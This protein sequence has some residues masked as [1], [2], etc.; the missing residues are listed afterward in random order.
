MLP[1]FSM[2]TKLVAAVARRINLIKLWQI[3]TFRPE[4]L[5]E[6]D[7][8]FGRILGIAIVAIISVA[9]AR[10][11][12]LTYKHNL[13]SAFFYQTSFG[14]AVNFACNGEYNEIKP[15]QEVQRFLER[16]SNSLNSCSGVEGLSVRTIS[17]LESSMVYL[18]LVSAAAWKVLGFN[19]ESLF[20]VAAALS[21][22]FALASYS[23]LRVFFVSRLTSA[24][25]TS[26]VMSSA[27]VVAQIPQLRDFSKAPFLIGALA[28][29]G[30]AVL[31][32]HRLL[33]ILLLATGAGAL[34]SI[35]LGFRPDLKVVLPIA[36]LAPLLFIGDDAL[37]PTAVRM[38]L[39]WVGF[40]A[41]YVCLQLPLNLVGEA[42]G[43]G[44]AT[45]IPHVLI[46]GFAEHFLRA[47]LGMSDSSYSALRPYLDE[48]VYA[49]VNLF[50]GTPNAS[51][52][53]LWGSAQYDQVSTDLLRSILLLVPYDTFFRGLYSANAIGHL[54]INA[55]VW[56]VPLL[57]VTP[58]LLVVRLR[59]FL[60]VMLVFG[61]LIAVLSLQYDSRHAFYML[62]LGAV[63][64]VLS[65]SV[66][67]E[68]ARHVRSFGF[69]LPR[70]TAL[71]I[72]S[73]LLSVVLLA[74]SLT[75]LSQFLANSQRKALQN[76]VGTYAGLEWD[77]IKFRATQGEIEPEPIG[78]ADG[79]R[80]FTFVLKQPTGREPGIRSGTQTFSRLTFKLQPTDPRMECFPAAARVSANYKY[81]GE[82]INLGGFSLPPRAGTVTYYFPQA[83]AGAL[84]FT[85][86]ELDG[87]S[88]DCIVD[89]SVAKDFPAGTV[90]A[91]LLL[92]DGQLNDFQ[93]GD[94]ASVWRNFIN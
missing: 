73:I 4:Q 17:A 83:F 25:L 63:I 69:D 31:R 70:L 92:I 66:L 55:L 5:T 68:V 32:P 36:L 88:P 24:V 44:T 60:F 89:W 57:L 11:G 47:A 56:G 8:K 46:L 54:P 74:A 87:L 26:F 23:L 49:T 1:F 33:T 90:P 21:S 41:G 40:G 10:Q 7:R 85:D 78:T 37:R 64:I 9:A 20:V 27:P 52:P 71:K 72:G 76:L 12:A 45:F 79:E 15:N 2:S 34:V 48:F 51:A 3:E 81:V 50:G 30:A 77:A 14:P 29:I 59:S 43:T 18:E 16:R 61:T 42:V 94:W 62:L 65:G 13:P 53:T 93:R 84:Q 19:W 28:C 22:G 39:A 58:I 86:L 38:L 35:G 6:R 82:K 67:L 75:A 91:E 80:P